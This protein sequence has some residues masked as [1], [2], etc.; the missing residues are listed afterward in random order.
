MKVLLLSDVKGSGKK[1]DI[2]EVSDGYAKNFLLKKNLAKVA[3]NAVLSE[4]ASQVASDERNKKLALDKAQRVAS[5][6]KGKTFSVLAKT[7]ESGKLF[8]AITSKEISDALA[9]AGYDIDKRGIA[10]ASPIKNLGKHDITAKLF[11]GVVAKFSIMV[12]PE[13]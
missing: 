2:V 13:V 10:L 3:D 1:G 12:E 11:G 6:I 5:E 8:G 9:K 7:G 4:K